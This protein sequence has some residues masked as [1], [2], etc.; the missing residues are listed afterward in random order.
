MLDMTARFMGRT[1]P[2]DGGLFTN[3]GKDLTPEK[4]IEIYQ[5]VIDIFKIIFPDENYLLINGRNA[6]TF[7][8]CRKAWR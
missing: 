3:M 1:G 7:I 6:G 2:N 8:S 4:E 5:A